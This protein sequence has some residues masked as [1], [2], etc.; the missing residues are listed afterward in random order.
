MKLVGGD[1][2]PC[3]RE[4]AG[5]DVV[6]VPSERVVV[7]VLFPEKPG[8]LTLEHRTPDRTYTLA[9]VTVSEDRATPSLSDAFTVLRT[10]PELS[11]ERERLAPLVD[12]PPDKTLA[13]VA[14]MDM[15]EPDIGA[16]G[17]LI[18]TCP[19]HP[20]VVNDEPGRCPSCG[21]KLI[22]EAAPTGFACPMH[23]DVTSE[24]ADR[25]PQCGMKLIPA[26]LVRSEAGGHAAPG[27]PPQGAGGLGGGDGK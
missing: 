11:A 21:M 9:D 6:L 5:E 19:M 18:Y 23:P 20:E 3:E 10:D 16:D 26:R 24:T 13:F 4:Q 15:G 7:D 12:A 8:K 27:H 2:G 1:S 22:A 17:A 14:E 25:C